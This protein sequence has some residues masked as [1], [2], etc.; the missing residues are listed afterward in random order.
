MAL[1]VEDG[2][3]VDNAD[4]YVSRSDYIA[5]AATQG[6]TITDDETADVQLRKAAEFIAS[7][8]S[9][10]KGDKVQRDQSMAFPRS[11]LVIENFSWDSDE[12]PRQV[13]LCQQ[14]LALDVN[15]GIDLWNRPQSEST[16]IKRERVEGVVEVEYAVKEAGKLSSQSTG[17]ALLNSLLRQN[18]LYGIPLRRA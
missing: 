1:I 3:V 8:D 17:M 12:I 11:G 2:S 16:G 18:G 14:Q 7:Y 13:I 9:R 4:S 15:A 10:L 6:V 5:Y